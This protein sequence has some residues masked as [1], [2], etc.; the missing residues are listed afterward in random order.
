VMTLFKN[1][2]P[3]FVA[4]RTPEE[5]LLAG[6]WVSVLELERVGID[7][8]FFELGGSSPLAT[9][10]MSRIRDIFS[11]DL[12]LRC[13]F[14]SPTIAGLSK[15]LYQARRGNTL[16]P[17]RPVSRDKPLPLHPA[18]ERIW[19]QLE[20]PNITSYNMPGVLRLEGRLH[21]EAFERSLAA[22]V[23]RHECLRTCFPTVNGVLVAQISAINYQLSV[24]NLQDLPP[25]EQEL[26]VQRLIK[27]DAQ[28]PFNLFKGPL[29]RSTLLQLGVESHILLFNIHH[30]I[31]DEWSNWVF[32]NELSIL[33]KALTQG[34]SSP[35]LPLPIEYV[36]FVY[37]QRLTGEVLDKQVNYWKQQLSGLRTGLQLPADHPPPPV[38]SVWASI[39]YRSLSPA[40]TARLKKLSQ[41][42]GT[43]LFMTL[44]SAFASLL[45]RYTGQTDIVIGSPHPN[46]T[47]S[48]TDSLVGFFVNALVLRLNLEGNPRFEEVLQQARRVTLEAYAHQDI[49]FQQ[50]VEELQPE[51]NT[52]NQSPLL[53]VVLELQ[54]MPVEHL[55]L[56]GLKSEFSVPEAPKTVLYNLSLAIEETAQGLKATL[57]YNPDL[58]ERAT[59]ERLFG[60]FQTLLEGIVENPQQSIHK[61]P[62]LTETERQQFITWNDTAADYPRDKT[63]INLFEAQVEKTPLHVAVGFEGQQLTYQELNTRANQLAHHLQTL[64]V[65]PEVLVGICV[66][67]SFEMVIGLLGILKAGGAYLPLAQDYPTARLA[68]MLEDAQVP[69]LLTQ[70]NLKDKLPPSQASIV[71]L[72]TD[73]AVISQLSSENPESGVKPENL[74]YVIYTSGSTGKPKGVMIEHHSLLNH[75]LAIIGQYQLTAND[76]ILQFVTINF[77]VAAE[78]IFPT[79][80]CGA[81]LVL[82]SSELSASFAEFRQF[83]ETEKLTVLNL[84][85]PYWHEWVLEL[86]QA[87][88]HLPE[89]LRLVVV[90]DEA[91][92]LERLSTWQKMTDHQV[93]WLNAY[94]V[95]ETTITTTLYEPGEKIAV[96]IGRPIANTQIY[97]L[98]HHQMPVPIGV[99]GEL[100]IGGA[101]LA[102]GYL[103]R[104]ELT[105]EKFIPNPFDQETRLYKTGDLARYFPDG[106][107]EFIG[108]IDHQVKIRGFRVELGE[109]EARLKEHP[110]VQESVVIPQEAGNSQLIAYIVSNFM[111]ERI[112]YQSIC[113]AEVDGK[114]VTV[115][116]EDIS[117]SGICLVEI[118]AN[119]TKDKHIRLCLPLLSEKEERW[120]NGTVEWVDW[121]EAGIYFQLTQTEQEVLEQ[122]IALSRQSLRRILQ[123]QV[124]KNLRT[125][126]KNK[127]PDYMLPHAIVLIDT[128]PLTPN[129]KIDCRALVQNNSLIK[130]QIP[131]ED[132]FGASRTPEEAL[133]VEIWADM[134]GLCK[135][136]GIHDDFFELGGHSLLVTQ[137]ISR[138]QE[139]FSIELPLDSLFESPTIAGIAKAINRIRQAETDVV[140]ATNSLIDFNAEAVL[141][142]TIQPPATPV[143]GYLTEPHSIFLTGATGFLGAYLLYELLE[144]TTAN[145]YCLVR[146]S[147]AEEGKNR[148]Q[149]KLESYF[150]WN[151]TFYSRIIPLVGDLSQPLLGLSESVFHDLAGQIDVIYH[152]GAM[153]NFVYPYSKLKATNVLG[154]QEILKLASQI[155]AKPVHLISSLSVFS[156]SEVRV[157]R[158]SEIG[159]NIQ[160]I[161]DGYSQ[162]K[163]V[164]EKLVMQARDR[165]LPVCIYRAT[166]ISGH[167]QTGV[168]NINDLFTRGIKGCIQLG[169]LPPV[170]DQEDNMV[171]VDYVSRAII[172]LSRQTESLGKIFHFANPS[173]FRWSDLF[174]WIRSLGYPLEQIS[175]PQWRTELNRHKE[176]AW[177][178]ILSLFNQD[179]FEKQ[180]PKF[181]CQ[182]TIEGLAGSDIVCPPVNSKLLDI[183]FSYFWKSGFL[184]TP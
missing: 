166:N 2:N 17:I 115:R 58:F 38:P 94:G 21:S 96:P 172:H 101:G 123:H 159:N 82:R 175:Y 168:S 170:D 142:P 157:A 111:P 183:Y 45:Y 112:L 184:E 129:G 136:I 39:L 139:T 134:L 25:E 44:L 113:K 42:T 22:L 180:Y 117:N 27:E 143:D 91:V 171:P 75:N 30:I 33:Y 133:L 74:V 86:S 68:L 63:I 155:K 59:I 135:T 37:W 148:L 122:S 47:H 174:N 13:L 57:E 108:R 65:K 160:N 32:Y 52:R 92:M 95:T 147:N 173:Y 153:V 20:D 10:V 116:T 156:D 132:T 23:Q 150:F 11:L 141:E 34:K 8:N 120:L 106:N 84:P 99:Q 130:Y 26:E 144:Q 78:E 14:E 18:Q 69:V 88:T 19:F 49:P 165:G 118:P 126:L 149:T 81:E 36:D 1:I 41:Q 162:S 53:Q 71:C 73:W 67:R 35:L 80:L 72:D 60:H 154:T 54:N 31:F 85:T 83:I 3:T 5:E 158:E 64:G 177:Y 77:D 90:G 181:D 140:V 145:I 79:L 56:P 167:S 125:Y 151:D 131:S 66:E 43:T 103:N 46:R 178:P 179:I 50:L 6:I 62:L 15:H 169:M 9:Q 121:P 97:I 24:T 102:R 70:S 176:N 93:K 119:L 89:S 105:A 7:D 28:R 109:I 12:P 104:P 100:H 161:D 98:D 164:A 110:D 114:T 107:I 128:L 40:L 138:I 29:F 4:P 124:T 146:S 51:R 76:R 182:K 163:W 87:R 16:P 152:N 137:L 48:Q 127:L 55:E 61:L